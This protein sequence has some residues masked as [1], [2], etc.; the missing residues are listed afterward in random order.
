M[1]RKHSPDLTI[2]Q[3]SFALMLRS[4]RPLCLS[5]TN[6][7]IDSEKRD[8][9]H[10][11]VIHALAYFDLNAFDAEY[12]CDHAGVTDKQINKMHKEDT[13][14]NYQINYTELTDDGATRSYRAY[15]NTLVDADRLAR[16]VFSG[17]QSS[18]RVYVVVL[19]INKGQ[20]IVIQRY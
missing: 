8:K 3:I 13:T 16:L 5:G 4:I 15:A 17:S 10:A 6:A 20:W 11:L 12:F 2:E 18:S 9:W 19:A 7:I 14:M 1:A